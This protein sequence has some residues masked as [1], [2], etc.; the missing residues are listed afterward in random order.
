MST[1]PQFQLP[2]GDFSSSVYLSTSR[3]TRFYRG[4]LSADTDIVGVQVSVRGGEFTASPDLLFFTDTDFIIPNPE[5]YPDGLPLLTGENTVVIRATRFGGAAEDASM[6]VSLVSEAALDLTGEPPTNIRCESFNKSVTITVDGIESSKVVGYNIY[7]ST[8]PGGGEGYTL[9]NTTPINTPQVKRSENNFAVLD[10]D[11]PKSVD[12]NGNAKAVPQLAEVTLLQRSLDGETFSVD[13]NEVAALPTNASQFRAEVRLFAYEETETF[14]FEHDRTAPKT[15]VNNT[16]YVS[17]WVGM[18]SADP[19]YYVATAVYY[20]EATRQETESPYS[21]EVAA[22]PTTVVANL[23]NLPAVSRDTL[24]RDAALSI[25]KTN[26]EVAV[27]PGSVIRDLFIDPFVSESLRIRTLIDFMHRATSFPTLLQIDDPYGLGESLNPYKSEYKSRLAAALYLDRSS[28]IQFYIDQCFEKLAANF[29]T[30]RKSGSY[31]RG[32]VT[33]FTKTRPTASVQIPLGTQVTGGGGTFRTTQNI[34]LPLENLGAYYNPTA[35]EYQISVGIRAVS[36]GTAGNV[37]KG[38]IGSTGVNMEVRNDAPTFGG[39]SR[40]SN[41]Q[42]AVRA[43]KRLS[44]VDTGTS[45]GYLYAATSL[46]GVEEVKVVSAG[47][48]LMQRDYDPDFEKHLGGR[49]DIWLRGDKTSTVSDTFAFS[50]KYARDIQFELISGISEQLEFRAVD[51][52]LTVNSP[53]LAMLD[54]TS[55]RLGIQNASTGEYFD[56]TDYEI[57]S[58]N[59]IKLSNDIDQPHVDYGDVV[60]G[61]YRYRTGTDYILSNQ[62]VRRI[63]SLRGESTGTI[64]PE[65]YSLVRPNSPLTTGRSSQAGAFLKVEVPVNA[66]PSL[67]VPA[68]D[69][70]SVVDERHLITSDYI[71]YLGR[72]G[73]LPLSIKVTSLDGLTEYRGPY[74][75][76]GASDY[77]IIDGSQT[78]P[79]GIQRTFGSRIQDGETVLISYSH[80]ENLTVTYDSNLIVEVAQE[81]INN[82]KHLTADVLVKETTEVLVNI[83]ATVIT[84]RGYSAAVADNAIR[85]QLANLFNSLALGTPIRQSD[86]IEAMDSASG[87]SHVLMPL[88]Q[89]SLADGSQVIREIVDVGVYGDTLRIHEWSTATANVYLLQNELAHSTSNGGGAEYGH[90]VGIFKSDYAM[91]MASIAPLM[92]RSVNQAYI[93]GDS[94]M[95]VPGYSDDETIRIQGYV[96]P[97]EIAARRKE[98]TSNRILVSLPIGQTP[99]ECNWSVTYTTDGDD[100][101]SDL[102]IGPS[103]YFRL[104]E[105]VFTFDEDRP[106]SRFQSNRGY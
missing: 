59:T 3:D 68:G 75:E 36:V 73:A 12:A 79:V 24:T 26:P 61:D 93:I 34:F 74:D 81:D 62:P 32:E 106:S 47:D 94:G 4:R 77:S 103:S 85:L 56:L 1:G 64:S 88:L 39:T 78:S 15:A 90:Y 57:T 55:P 100:G 66:D 28:D 86:I 14:S 20:D 5:V 22:N 31:A 83:A 33:F 84:K 95:V 96:T 40:E 35:K 21:P 82:L 69:L 70:L 49:V 63:T 92:G 10:A 41:L 8:S 17:G 13:L 91:D 25:A 45:Q 101:A 18:D 30:T 105:C 6:T 29:G 44:S 87:V 7:A 50:F 71:E 16:N 76:T 48:P 53:M 97:Q 52:N 65:V 102:E 37:S 19:L 104:G 72:L 23:K 60:L 27:Q 43:Q 9:V 51:E 38:Q 98:L 2:N 11:I 42:L 58:H 67:V 89:M 54:S 80:D 46:A 99:D